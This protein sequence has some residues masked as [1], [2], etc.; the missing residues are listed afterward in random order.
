MITEMRAYEAL[1]D[2]QGSVIPECIGIFT[3]DVFD[4]CA[5]GFH[6]MDGMTLQQHFEIE[7][8]NV[9]IDLFRSIWRKIEQIHN[10]HVVHG[11]VRPENIWITGNEDVFIFDFDHAL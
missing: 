10:C 8:P 1:H 3:I 6:A 5:L 2:L 7:E 11:D 9:E 4:G